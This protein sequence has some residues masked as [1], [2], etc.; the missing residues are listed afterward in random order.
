ML[1]AFEPSGS[2][3]FEEK[4]KFPAWLKIFTAGTMLLAMVTVFIAAL[5]V[6]AEEKAEM[7]IG[8]GIVLV[9]EIVILFLFQ[10]VRFE[11][12]VTTNGIYFRWKPWQKR[13]RVI[14]KEDIESFEV[15]NGPR[16]HYG[17]GWFPGYGWIHNASVGEGMQFYLMNGKK[18]FF[19]TS[20][21]SFFQRAL[22]NLVS[23]NPKSR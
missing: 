18:I 22:Q 17:I 19:S 16:L 1:K 7:W 15:R 20:D 21:I 23:S 4:Q 13:F 3:L 14:E 8:F 2:M 9:T 5:T 6:P 12:V 10:N 11:K